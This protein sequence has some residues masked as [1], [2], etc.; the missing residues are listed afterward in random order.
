[1]RRLLSASRL[2]LAPWCVALVA[3]LGAPGPGEVGYPYNVAGR[4]T[5]SLTVG[6]ERYAVTVEVETLPE[7]T[8]TGRLLVDDPVVV[9]G[10][11]A[12]TVEADTLTWRSSYRVPSRGCGGVA[13]GRGPVEPGGSG[14]AG[15]LR[16]DGSC[17]GALTGSFRLSREGAPGG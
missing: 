7:G 12:G 17:A 11:F 15:S 5:G 3:C 8:V 1:M 4:Y 2:L 10:D 6:E 9:R 14:V 13:R 16:V